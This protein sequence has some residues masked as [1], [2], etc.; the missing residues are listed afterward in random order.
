MLAFSSVRDDV[1]VEEVTR[2][3]ERLSHE[4]QAADQPGARRRRAEGAGRVQQ[5]RR[6]DR[7]RQRARR[8]VRSAGRFRRDRRPS[9]PASRRSARRVPLAP[10]AP[11]T[12]VERLRGRRRDARDLPRGSARGRRVGARRERRAAIDARRHRAADDAA[13]RLPHAQGQLAHGRAE[14][15]RRGRLVVRAGLQHA[16][17][18]AA[19]RR[20]AAGRVHRAGCWA[21]SAT[22][23]RTSPRIARASATSARSQAA[24]ARRGAAARGAGPASRHRLAD[25]HAAPT[26]RAAPIST[27]APP[28]PAAAP[29]RGRA[30]EDLSFELDLSDARSPGRAR[31]AAERAA[32]ARADAG[33]RVGDVRPLRRCAQRCA[34][35]DARR[36]SSST[37]MP[38]GRGRPRSRQPGSTRR[39]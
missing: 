5:G 13:P 20:A 16:A 29:A 39:G 30:A 31:L 18:R 23:S 35:D 8:A 22:G 21:I 3:L 33:R 1:P 32:G 11:S 24:A 4:A 15:V 38:S 37:S 27:C 10:M 9:R 6:S 12:L 28:E 2:D 26:C 14:G 25:R 34:A 36:T 19:R 17:G 7:C